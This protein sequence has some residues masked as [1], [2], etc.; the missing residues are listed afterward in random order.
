MTNTT[1]TELDLWSENLMIDGRK[2]KILI[3]Q[4]FTGCKIGNEGAKKMSESLM[5]NNALTKLNLGGFWLMKTKGSSY[6]YTV[7]LWIDNDIG[8]QGIIGLSKALKINSTLNELDLSSY[9]KIWCKE[10]ERRLSFHIKD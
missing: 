5:K 2:E 3:R 4:V 6:K 9:N 7:F 10:L 1:L 8:N